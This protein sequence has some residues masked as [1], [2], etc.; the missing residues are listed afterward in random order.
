M[1]TK[2]DV[3]IL[4]RRLY[5]SRQAAKK[6]KRALVELSARIGDCVADL[7]EDLACW[8][9]R[10]GKDQWCEVC[11]AKLPLW[12][13]WRCKSTASGAALRAVLRAGKRTFLT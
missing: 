9:S 4:V 7:P 11:K 8:C 5:E 1:N 3:E 6:A 10:R 13:E 12:E 2:L